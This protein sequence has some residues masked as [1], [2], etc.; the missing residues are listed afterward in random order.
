MC[1]CVC[2]CVCCVR[3]V[4][5]SACDVHLWAR[6]CLGMVFCLTISL[7]RSYFV[8]LPKACQACL[9]SVA[10]FFNSEVVSLGLKGRGCADHHSA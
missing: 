9:P 5:A 3:V 1:V 7:T 6:F 10:V 2:V 8:F 4:C